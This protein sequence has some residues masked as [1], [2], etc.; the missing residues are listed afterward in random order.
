MTSIIEKLH[1]SNSKQELSS[2]TGSRRSSTNSTSTPYASSGTNASVINYY[3]KR[4]K[5]YELL[6]SL[7]LSKSLLKAFNMIFPGFV[8]EHNTT[9]DSNDFLTD[10]QNVSIKMII[11]I[12]S[13][14]QMLQK[15]NLKFFITLDDFQVG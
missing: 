9:S 8:Y 4:G 7:I 15:L 13:F 14:F 6:S 10:A 2:L 11:F 5:H 1:I 3:R 12:I